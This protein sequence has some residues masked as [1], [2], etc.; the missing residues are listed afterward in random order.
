[1]G[2]NHSR[3][4]ASASTSVV[5]NGNRVV[6]SSSTIST[7]QQ[8]ETTLTNER[9]ASSRRGV[10]IAGLEFKA[11][12][13]TGF[14]NQNPGVIHVDY[15]DNSERTFAYFA[16][17]GIKLFRIPF[18]W[19]RIQPALGGPLA[20]KAAA[21]DPDQELDRLVRQVDYARNCGGSVILDVHNYGAYTLD[22]APPTI[23]PASA[24]AELSVGSAAVTRAHF[25][26]LW[27]RLSDV[28]KDNSAVE[29]Y[30]LMNEPF[31]VVDDWHAVSLDVVNALR[32]VKH[33]NKPIL[34]AGKL[35]SSAHSWIADNGDRAWIDASRNIIYE[36]H[37]YFD[38]SNSGEYLQTFAQEFGFDQRIEF[39]GADRLAPFV[40]WCRDN[41]V[42]GCIGEYAIPNDEPEWIPVLD[43]FLAALDR[44]GMTSC[45]WAAGEWWGNYRLSVQPRLDFRQAPPP[46]ER[47]IR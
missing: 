36:A 23:P 24:P 27:E 39:R 26:D 41:Q 15:T 34:I 40:Q 37:C 25:V 28:F 1:M 13:G 8:V 6:V 32:D 47:L 3:G 9:K 17:L 46:L 43:R 11:E 7:S 19:E 14:T 20:R 16:S 38:S 35:F 5:T 31:K 44:A 2:A 21:S 30:G 10:N 45:Y 29:A 18:R 12:L 22:I 33:D 4:V 42:R